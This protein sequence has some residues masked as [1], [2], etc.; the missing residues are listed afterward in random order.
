LEDK[1]FGSI[2]KDKGQAQFLLSVTGIENLKTV[3]GE[4]WKNFYGRSYLG[5]GLLEQGIT[6]RKY[7]S[8]G[9][10]LT[11]RLLAK[12][13]IDKECSDYLVLA[14]KALGCFGGA[15]AKARKGFGSLSLESLKIDEIEKWCNPKDL[16]ELAVQIKE[17]LGMMEMK[18]ESLSVADVN[19]PEYTA[20]S[21]FAKVKILKVGDE[22]TKLLDEIGKELL[23]Y[24]SYGSTYQS[25]HI[26]KLPWGEKAEQNFAADHD[27]MYEL[28]NRQS[29]IAASHPKRV[30]FGLPHNYFFKSTFKK[31]SIE[32]VKFKRRS[33][34]LFIHVHSLKSGKYAI[35]ATLLPARFLPEGEKIKIVDEGNSRNHDRKIEHKVDQNVSYKDIEKFL[36]R[37]AFKDGVVVFP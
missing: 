33:S 15:G 9:T 14:L 26:H 8:Q 10:R 32:S 36:D 29:K 34:P 13:T 35:V 2:D 27:L 4:N 16:S 21:N 31:G 11:L 30:V 7:I 23:R 18:K 5:Y 6:N 20:F 12:K 25:P 37:D 3:E 28:M 22:P 17:L 24:R 19:Y 1:L